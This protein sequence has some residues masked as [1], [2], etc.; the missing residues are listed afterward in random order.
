MVMVIR[1]I[2]VTLF[3][4]I[5]VYFSIGSYWYR[6]AFLLVLLTAVIVLFTYIARLC[7]NESFE[8]VG[9]TLLLILIYI[10]INKGY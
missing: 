8:Y 5:L 1:I 2:L 4:S 7:P 9:I 6:Y 10:Y 3:N